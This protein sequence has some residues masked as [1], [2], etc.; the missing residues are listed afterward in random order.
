MEV[1]DR[2]EEGRSLLGSQLP[3][4]VF[5]H[6]TLISSGTPAAIGHPSMRYNVLAVLVYGFMSAAALQC[7][8]D[9]LEEPCKRT[10]KKK[11]AKTKKGKKFV[12]T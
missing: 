12:N 4:S 6:S 10:K 9:P 11:R 8:R 5:P 7:G 2:R 1:T 3:P